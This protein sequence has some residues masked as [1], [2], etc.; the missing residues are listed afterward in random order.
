ML[1][2]TESNGRVHFVPLQTQDFPIASRTVQLKTSA[3]GSFTAVQIGQANG[4]RVQGREVV[5]ILVTAA[6]CVVEEWEGA[7]MQIAPVEPFVGIEILAVPRVQTMLEDPISGNSVLLERPLALLIGYGNSV[8]PP[9]HPPLYRHSS[10]HLQATPSRSV[11]ELWKEASGQ[12]NRCAPQ[13]RHSRL[14]ICL[15]W[16]VWSTTV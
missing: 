14:Y 10:W 5:G 2:S 9:S 13:R 11:P 4:V 1:Q 16:H 12:G 6:H 15:C 8:L 3:G 7:G